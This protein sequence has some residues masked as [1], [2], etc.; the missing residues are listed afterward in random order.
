MPETLFLE[1]HINIV[2]R[3]KLQR[4]WF[5]CSRQRVKDSFAQ[6]VGGPTK[7]KDAET[8]QEVITLRGDFDSLMIII[9]YWSYIFVFNFKLD[10]YRH[11]F[12][13]CLKNR[14]PSMSVKHQLNSG[15]RL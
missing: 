9:L 13:S 12:H 4:F 3:V 10:N 6:P 7:Q 14:K 5:I 15:I 2:N 1:Q 11:C 8:V